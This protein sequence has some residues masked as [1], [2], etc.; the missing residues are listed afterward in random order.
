MYVKHSIALHRNIN[1]EVFGV[2]PEMEQPWVSV[3]V[4]LMGDLNMVRGRTEA[5]LL[6]CG[7]LVLIIKIS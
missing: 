3:K 4:P 1:R 5:R 7:I 2:H 6:P